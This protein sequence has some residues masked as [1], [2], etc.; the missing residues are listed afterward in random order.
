MILIAAAALQVQA[1]KPATETKPLRLGIVGLVHG[2]AG[3][4]FENAL[5]RKD[6]QIVGV[7]EADTAVVRTYRERF[8]LPARL[9][10]ATLEE[11]LSAERPEAVG[12]FSSTF[13]HR[14][15]VEACGKRGVHVMMEKPMAV[16]YDD[17]L[18]IRRAADEGKIQVL[19]NY[20]TTWYP[21]TAELG[22]MAKAG[23]L[24]PLRKL[25]AHDG[26]QGPK[27]IGCGWEFLAWLT[28][29]VLN[30]AGA[31]MD[32]GCY[33]A[34][35]FTALMGNERPVTV[36]AVTQQIKPDVYPKV[37]DEATIVITYPKAQGIIQASWNWPYSRKDLEVYGTAGS[38]MATGRDR[39]QTRMGDAPHKTH[40]SKPAASPE[41]D[42][43]SYLTAV[44]RGTLKPSGLSSLENNLIV[45]EIL[46]AARRS[47]ATG[48]TVKLPRVETPPG[49]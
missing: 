37:D 7:V 16:S 4:M 44:V 18:A 3:G 12:V 23:T 47:A 48:Q 34:N 30:G 31:L 42:P 49:H 39:L 40:V 5:R 46:D 36:T 14:R 13:D 26:H 28:D 27:E 19:V 8:H 2:H 10:F 22:Q 45:C 9:F 11:F 20:E 1:R 33:G 15:I 6:V 35:L 32:F 41:D 17:A 24:G 25:V 21:T 29:P 43:L 38:A